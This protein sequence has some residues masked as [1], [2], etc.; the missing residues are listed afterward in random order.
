MPRAWRHWPLVLIAV[1]AM[2][3]PPAAADAATW[4]EVAGPSA[5][6]PRAI[7]SPGRGCLDGAI[8][9]P[10]D[11][12]GF[13]VMRLSRDRMY[14][15][16]QLIRFIEE[17]AR[18]APSRGWAG[19][20]VGDLAQPRGGPMR[21]GHRSHQSGL[22]V[23]VWLTPAPQRRLTAQEREELGAVSVVASDG[24]SV[25]RATWTPAH[26]QVL[27]VA[28]EHP[29]VDRIFVHAAI[30]KALC[31][32]A[33]G[34]RRWLRKVRPWWGHDAH[35]HVRLVC[36]P[37]DAECESPEPLPA[38]DGCDPSLEWWFS[39]EAAAELRKPKAAARTI[40]LDD[41]PPAC[42]HVLRGG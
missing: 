2:A 15:H 27:R 23:D 20:L 32:T 16:P 28:A 25:D 26:A 12:P 33:V 18:E 40:T 19:L 34:D 3:A 13:Q 22:D 7:G 5:G 17:L 30:K 9:L 35:F 6:A 14:G 38:G 21:S 37:G 8:A 24:R 1:T 29:D 31:E 10:A 36:P 42:R 4:W 41:L 39:E 11:G